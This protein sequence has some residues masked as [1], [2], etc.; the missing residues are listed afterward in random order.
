MNCIIQ[1]VKLYF[2][3]YNLECNF[4][5]WIVK[6]IIF[7]VC[8]IQNYNYTKNIIKILKIIVRIKKYGSGG[9]NSPLVC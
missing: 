5:L 8:I 6:S 3:L 2:E 1:N 7:T 4:S 9:R